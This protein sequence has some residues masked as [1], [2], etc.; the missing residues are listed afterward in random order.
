MRICFALHVY[1][2]IMETLW[3]QDRELN[4]W[5]AVH[6][7]PTSSKQMSTRKTNE[8]RSYQINRDPT[9]LALSHGWDL[10]PGCSYYLLG[11]QRHI[12]LLI[13]VLQEHDNAAR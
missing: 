11:L 5:C 8:M 12:P 2:N 1:K 9:F 10:V 13:P 4:L 7:W 6:P 3:P